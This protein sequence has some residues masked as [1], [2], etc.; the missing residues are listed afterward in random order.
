MLRILVFSSLGQEGAVSGI[1]TEGIGQAHT[2]QMG[3]ERRDLFVRLG[4]RRSPT[5]ARRARQD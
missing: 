1:I 5:A 2:G 3:Q 4:G